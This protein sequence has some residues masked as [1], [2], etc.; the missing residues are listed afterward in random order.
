VGE[1]PLGAGAQLEPRTIGHFA[2]FGRKY[3]PRA[4]P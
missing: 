2:S 1:D 3:R 4:T